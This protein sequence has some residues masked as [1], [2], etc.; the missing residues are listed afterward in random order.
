MQVGPH[1]RPADGRAASASRAQDLYQPRVTF[2]DHQL[3]RSSGVFCRAVTL[4]RLVTYAT[5]GFSCG[6]K[7]HNLFVEVIRTISIPVLE[8][9]ACKFSKLK[10]LAKEKMSMSKYNKL[11][12]F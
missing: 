2:L 1:R 8:T 12:A 10:R 3:K 5:L 9:W 11:P 4:R 6:G 7:Q